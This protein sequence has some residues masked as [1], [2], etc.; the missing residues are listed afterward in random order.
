VTAKPE[1]NA[2]LGTV[3]PHLTRHLERNSQQICFTQQ[4]YASQNPNPCIPKSQLLAVVVL[5]PMFVVL[6]GL[7]LMPESQNN[8]GK[9]I[10]GEFFPE[11]LLYGVYFLLETP[12]KY[13]FFF[14]MYLQIY[15]ISI[16]KDVS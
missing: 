1:I 8:K 10:L 5:D 4:N 7:F 6:D 16:L 14:H 9:Q 3:G 2:Q 13:V 11:V 12:L 15:E